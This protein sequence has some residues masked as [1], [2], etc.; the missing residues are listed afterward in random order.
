[1]LA[2]R[3]FPALTTL[4]LIDQARLMHG[5]IN[6]VVCGAWQLAGNDARA[7]HGDCMVL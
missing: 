7:A 6:E 3:M 2:L 4:K 1:M 5:H